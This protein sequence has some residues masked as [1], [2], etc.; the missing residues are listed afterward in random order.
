MFLEQSVNLFMNNQKKNGNK[1]L[2]HKLKQVMGM[3]RFLEQALADP[4]NSENL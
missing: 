4:A 1:R 3:L 2:E